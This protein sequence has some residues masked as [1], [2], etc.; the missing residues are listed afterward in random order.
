QPTANSQQPTANSQ[1]PTANS[2]QPTACKSCV[3]YEAPARGRV[4]APCQP[5]RTRS[6]TLSPVSVATGGPSQRFHLSALVS[7][8]EQL[9]A[10]FIKPALIQ[11]PIHLE[12]VAHEAFDF[13]INK[14]YSHK[15]SSNKCQ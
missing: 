7:T 4:K 9:L 12:L 1:Q 14:I 10:K 11:F 15:I 13:K 5:L 3:F 6:A 2:Q 8:C